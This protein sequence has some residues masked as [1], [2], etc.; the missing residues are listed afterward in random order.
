[1]EI[2]APAHWRT[3]DFLSDLHLDRPDSPTLAG[4]AH[5]LQ[6]SP[7]QAL[8]VL[9]DLFEAWVG[10]DALS[11]KDGVEQHV[12]AL[13]C[14]AAQRMDIF[15]HDVEVNAFS[16]IA[17]MALGRNALFATAPISDFTPRT[18]RLA[19]S[20]L[21]GIWGNHLEFWALGAWPFW[22]FSPVSS[23]VARNRNEACGGSVRGK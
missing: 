5:Y 21:H 4:F 8:M 22:P 2:S 11:Q 23:L 16:I 13:V 12:A 7:A 19:K 1:M 14:Q 6:H 18:R 10:D 20:F 17:C 15:I 3:V 9:G